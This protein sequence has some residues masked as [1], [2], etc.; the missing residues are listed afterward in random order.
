MP[1][2]LTGRSNTCRVAEPGASATYTY[3]PNGNL[4]S[5]TEG[6][7][8]WTYTWNA[9]NQLTK[10]EK[11]GAEVGRFAYDP[12]GR[13][14]EKVVGAVTTSFAYEQ[15]DIIREIHGGAAI[16]YVHGRGFDE[17]LSAESGGAPSYLHRDGLG[18]IVALSNAVGAASSLRQYDAWGNVEVGA[19]ESGYSFTGREWDVEIGLYYYRARYY[20]PSIGRF[21]SEDPIGFGGGANFFAYV[22][23]RVTTHNDPLGLLPVHY[24]PGG[25]KNPDPR[26]GERLAGPSVCCKGGQYVLCVDPTYWA[27]GSEQFQY[28][29]QTHETYHTWQ[30]RD[31]PKPSCGQCSGGDPCMALPHPKGESVK[32]EC[33]AWWISYLCYRG[34]GAR[35]PKGDLMEDVAMNIVNR[36]KE[37]GTF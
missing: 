36:C 33:R 24:C 7:D 5:K 6:T 29:T 10:V 27:Q 11:N 20:A 12:L 18:S 37:R 9:E 15:E 16:A 34:T 31:D 30:A 21:I 4:A 14:V 8:N 32:R 3:D 28:C 19:N 17:P 13:R 2:R 23:G 22:R 25:P 35:D 26:F 1:N